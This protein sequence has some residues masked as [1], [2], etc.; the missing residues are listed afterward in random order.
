MY[1]L[2]LSCSTSASAREVAR[3]GGPHAD[4]FP[5]VYSHQVFALFYIN[6]E[7]KT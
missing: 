7:N 1:A 5:G 2:S 6:T 3:P 4:P